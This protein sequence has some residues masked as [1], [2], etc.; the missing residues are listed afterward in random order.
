MTEPA[1]LRKVRETAEPPSTER[2]LGRNRLRAALG[3][4]AAVLCVEV[5]GGLLSG[6]LALLADAAHLFADIAALTMAYA[7]MSLAQRAPTGRHSF[8]LYR[9]EILAAFV[10]AQ[11]LLVIAIFILFQAVQRIRA[12]IPI[13]TGLM[14]WV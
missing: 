10:N 7:A 6:S 2:E 11:I 12:P 3:L 9:A 5:A 1:G 8:G 4:T 13:Q 14:F